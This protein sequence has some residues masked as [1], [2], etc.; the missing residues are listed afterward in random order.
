MGDS[1]V[2]DQGIII[3]Y[4]DDSGSTWHTL[5]SDLNN[6]GLYSWN[7][8]SVNDGSNYL[9]RVEATNSAG[10]TGRDTSDSTFEIRNNP[11]QWLIII[12]IIAVI[13]VVIVS[14]IAMFQRKK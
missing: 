10:K 12:I 2:N 1:I 7:T 5:A 8:T 4:S 11:F 3:R 9:I 14:I 6:T 13:I